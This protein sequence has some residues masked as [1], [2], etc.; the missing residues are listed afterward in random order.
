[1]KDQTHIRTSK[2]IPE[3]SSSCFSQNIFFNFH[4]KNDYFRS[5]LAMKQ[6]KDFLNKQKELGFILNDNHAQFIADVI[7]VRTENQSFDIT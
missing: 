7:I 3:N 5:Y 2:T 6:I 1:M 4:S